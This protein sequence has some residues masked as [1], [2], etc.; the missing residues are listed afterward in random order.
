[1]SNRLV[2]LGTVL[3]LSVAVN[4]SLS[5]APVPPRVSGFKTPTGIRI[6]SREPDNPFTLELHGVEIKP[7]ASDRLLWSID[8]K[9]IELLTVR[10]RWDLSLPTFEWEALQDY[11]QTNLN[12]LKEFGWVSKGSDEQFAFDTGEKCLYWVL[13]G[14]QSETRVSVATLNGDYVIVLTVSLAQPAGEQEVRDYLKR[15]MLS[16]KRGIG[17]KSS[18]PESNPEETGATLEEQLRIRAALFGERQTALLNNKL[19]TSTD[20]SIVGI[21]HLDP[22]TL[23][24][25]TKFMVEIEPRPCSLQ[26]AVFD[27]QSSHSINLNAFDESSN[28]FKYWDP[29]GKGS[30]LTRENNQAHVAATPHPTEKREWLVK[31]DE[32]ET[33]LYAV[34]DTEQQIIALFRL[35]TVLAGPP[36][37]AIETYLGIRTQDPKSPEISEER[38]KAIQDYLIREKQ[39]KQAVTMYQVRIALYPAAIRDKPALVAKLQ[40]SGEMVV[41]SELNVQDSGRLGPHPVEANIAA[42]KKTDFF[43]FFHLEQTRSKVDDSQHT[44]MSFRPDAPTFHDLV[45]LKVK[46]NQDEFILNSELSIARSFLDGRFPNGVFAADLAKSFL[47]F[48]IPEARQDPVGELIEEIWNRSHG[49][50]KKIP[51]PAAKRAEAGLPSMP[52][53]AYLTYVGAQESYLQA[54]SG[55]TLRLNNITSDGVRYLLIS[56]SSQR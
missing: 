47:Q 9:Q 41:E 53:L 54:L 38:L 28:T 21:V 52:S 23:A 24:D 27:G 55:G 12:S 15:N 43:E 36:S 22:L 26:I 25:L 56:V 3:A 49:E 18:A 6:V 48:S 32:L 39:F 51:V 50:V 17:M 11:K 4:V 30:F 35:C 1:M 19:M 16:L 42:A 2:V 40:E 20:G 29:W 46:L 8:G 5:A 10:R 7:M 45:E 33:V 37:E 44:I 14:K 34:L 13:S 31:A